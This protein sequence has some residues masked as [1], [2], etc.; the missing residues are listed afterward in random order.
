MGRVE[1][2]CEAMEESGGEGLAAR[3]PVLVGGG[4]SRLASS[5][6]PHSSGQA[7]KP[8]QFD[9]GYETTRDNTLTRSL[10]TIR[11]YPGA[12]PAMLSPRM[13]L[14]LFRAATA[15]A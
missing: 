12:F 14:F 1:K 5:Q 2:R 8:S 11:L 10:S 6:A 7:T 4:F 3:G 15:M 13:Y 9:S